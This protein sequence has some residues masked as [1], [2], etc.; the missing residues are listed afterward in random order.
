MLAQKQQLNTAI[1]EVTDGTDVVTLKDEVSVE[2]LMCWIK[3]QSMCAR[4]FLKLDCRILQQDFSEKPGT[5]CKD[6]LEHSGE[7]RAKV[8]SQPINAN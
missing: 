1:S 5:M 3:K 7:L 2:G 4:G 8:K 6:F